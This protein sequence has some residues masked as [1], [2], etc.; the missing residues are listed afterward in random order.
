MR[1][2][3]WVRIEIWFRTGQISH[4]CTYFN[5]NAQFIRIAL[6]D[7][8]QNPPGLER[9]ATPK[10]LEETIG[11]LGYTDLRVQDVLDLHPEYDK[12]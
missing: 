7:S 9:I 1:V 3:A 8:D 11:H 10:T 5:G 4:T 2:K 6:Q 12:T